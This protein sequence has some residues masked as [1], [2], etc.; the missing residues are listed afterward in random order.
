MGRRAST[1]KEGG[2]N[3]RE[4]GKGTEPNSQALVCSLLMHENLL[5][6][7]ERQHLLEGIRVS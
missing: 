5:L 4:N 6:S 7:K 2:D 3:Q 1:D